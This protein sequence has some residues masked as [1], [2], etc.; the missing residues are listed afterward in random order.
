MFCFAASCWAD[1][2]DIDLYIVRLTQR[3]FD[4]FE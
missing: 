2:R 3:V 1:D 4:D